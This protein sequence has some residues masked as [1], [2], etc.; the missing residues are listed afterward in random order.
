[1][2]TFKSTEQMYEILGSLLKLLADHPV[3]G[4]KYRE[5][6]IVTRY[7]LS[8]P[9]GTIWLTEQGEVICGSNPEGLKPTIDMTLSG[10]TCHL[11]WLKKISLPIALAKG[12]VKTKGPLPKV[13]KMLPLLKPAYEAYPEIAKKYDLQPL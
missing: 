1:M 2:P 4:P 6:K 5:S 8:D 13:L 12:K 11:F 3:V 9:N 7:N 10:D